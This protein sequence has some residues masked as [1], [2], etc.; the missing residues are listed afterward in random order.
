MVD[1]WLDSLVLLQV[2]PS[3][4]AGVVLAEEAEDPGGASAVMPGAATAAVGAP[5]A[6]PRTV[7]TAYHCVASGLRP[8]V[9]FRDGSD[10]PGRVIARDPAHDLALVE[11]DTRLPGLPLRA[12]T[13]A[14]GEPL[15]AL[16]HPFGQATGGKL[17]NL[18]VWSVSRGIVSGVGPW[19]VQT[20]APMN[21]GNSGGPLV[22]EQG[23]VIGIVSR[24]IDGDGI[25]F[26][27]RAG[28]V[29]ELWSE[30]DMGSFFG[31]SWG[32]GGGFF[33]GERAEVGVN[34]TVVVRERL[35]TR[36]WLGVGLGDGQ[37]F[38]LFTLAARQRVGRGPLSTSF[39]LGGGG[40]WFDGAAT[41]LLTGRI[42]FAGV[43][44]GAQ[45]EPGPWAWTFT[46]DVE[47]PGRLGV[48]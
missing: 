38:G 24:K 3:L 20:D 34:L 26:A 47:W 1:A 31:G 32:I 27:A 9:R 13:P 23:R 19:L 16:G 5:P 35:V 43:G 10:A 2:G 17:E 7:A 37:P 21:P 39:D 40:R 4:C 29:A 30:L 11:V 48:F 14:V 42:A 41:P 15:Y 22:D 12:D 25:G 18:L 8:L 28:R 33:Q 44:F 45:V 6:T 46:L 36:A